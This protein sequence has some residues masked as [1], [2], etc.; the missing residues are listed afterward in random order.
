MKINMHAGHNPDG[1]VACGAT[2]FLKESTEARNVK[3]AA[4]K[5][6]KAAGHTAYDCTVNNGTSQGDILRKIVTKCNVHT[7]DVDVSIHLNCGAGDKKGN[8]KT[9]GVEVYI[10]SENS[11]AK[12]KATRICKEIAKLG[13]KNRGVKVR[14]DLYVLNHTKAPALLVEC[15][16]VDDK[17]DAKLFDAGKMAKAIVAGLT[18]KS[19]VAPAHKTETK[20]E[21]KTATKKKDSSKTVKVTAKSGLNCRKGPG[22]KYGTVMAYPYGS[23]LKITEETNGW[24]KTSKGWVKLEYTKKI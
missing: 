4:I 16:F 9:T 12:E 21:T 15:C 3:N 6:L 13:F 24:G 8:G 14:K 19:T 1:K 11:K 10:A 5:S 18:G 22:T 23:T 20:T 2:G 7:V 17:D